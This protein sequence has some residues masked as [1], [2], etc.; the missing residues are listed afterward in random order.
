MDSIEIGDD[1]FVRLISTW[2]SAGT[3]LVPV[4]LSD[5]DSILL[6]SERLLALATLQPSR[7]EGP[8]TRYV[9]PEPNA[10]DPEASLDLSPIEFRGPIVARYALPP[11]C[12]RFAAAATIPIGSRQWA[13]FVLIVRSNDEEVFRARMSGEQPHVEINVPLSGVELTIE[14]TEGAHGPIQDRLILEYPMLLLQ[15]D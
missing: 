1:G 7:I 13:D 2:L 10:I 11:G 4:K 9:L 5:L 3:K 8:E 12:R 14:L 6:D 15:N